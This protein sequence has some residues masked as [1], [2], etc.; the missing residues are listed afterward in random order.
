MKDTGF[1]LFREFEAEM[2]SYWVDHG[3][4]PSNS[5]SDEYGLLCNNYINKL[6]NMVKKCI[7]ATTAG[8]AG[9]A[10]QYELF[11]ALGQKVKHPSHV[12]IYNSICKQYNTSGSRVENVYVLKKSEGKDA[13][14][15][16]KKKK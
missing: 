9:T 10:E 5:K 11:E 15:K 13:M 7:A 1:R 2:I 16:K 14:N 8:T 4:V 3:M 12:E 6:Q